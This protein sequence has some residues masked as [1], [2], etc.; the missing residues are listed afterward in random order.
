M[1]VYGLRNLDL[2]LKAVTIIYE[3][4][5][6]ELRLWFRTIILASVCRLDF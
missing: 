1:N 2:I 4:E 6:G 5:K 3:Q